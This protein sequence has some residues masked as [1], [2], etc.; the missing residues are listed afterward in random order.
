MSSFVVIELDTTAPVVRPGKITGKR[1]EILR[2]PFTVSKASSV[3]ATLR[4]PDG[5]VL[6][7]VLADSELSVAIPELPL[8]VAARMGAP[9]D[10]GMLS[11]T[12]TDPLG[13]TAT[14]TQTVP[15]S[16][17]PPPDPVP[18]PTGGGTSYSEGSAGGVLYRPPEREVWR[19][20]SRQRA[21]CRARVTS[22]EGSR[23]RARSAMTVRA[24]E[25]THAEAATTHVQLVQAAARARSDVTTT[26]TRRSDEGEILRLLDLGLL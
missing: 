16:D 15:L 25:R 9:A 23:V 21:A 11:I 22:A 20:R 3:T 10:A 4:L 18:T 26:I 19:W 14:T 5:L 2:V 6:D 7:L 8:T 1:G 17:T 13:N 24:V 12:A